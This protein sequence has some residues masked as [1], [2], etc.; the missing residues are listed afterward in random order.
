VLHVDPEA[1]CWDKKRGEDG[2]EAVVKNA[3]KSIAEANENSPNNIDI[4]T[5]V[6]NERPA[7]A[8]EDEARKGFTSSSWAW[9]TLN[10]KGGFDRKIEDISTGF[11]NPMA[12]GVAKGH[13]LKQPA[14][15]GLRILVPVSGSPVR[16]ENF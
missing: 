5:R 4:T 14:A 9:K 1:R 10:A 15:P 3:A 8:I 11:R 16:Q 2:L 6:P 12:I 13:H 7:E